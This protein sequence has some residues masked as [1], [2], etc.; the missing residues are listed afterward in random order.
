MKRLTGDVRCVTVNLIS[1]NL[2]KRKIVGLPLHPLSL[3]LPVVQ[4]SPA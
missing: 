4:K 1:Y 2:K 3:S